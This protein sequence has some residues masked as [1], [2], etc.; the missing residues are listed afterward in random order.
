[1]S[2]MHKHDVDMCTH[3]SYP[4]HSVFGES[5]CV[6][7]QTDHVSGVREFLGEIPEEVDE[8]FANVLHVLRLPFSAQRSDVVVKVDVVAI[9][10][11]FSR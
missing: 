7:P 1:M 6:G 11:H 2:S 4:I 3:L 8:Q 5:P 9:H 10:V